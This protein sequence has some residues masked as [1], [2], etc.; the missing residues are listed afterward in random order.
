AWVRFSASVNWQPLTDFQNKELEASEER[1][2]K[3]KQ[4]EMQRKE[5]AR[6]GRSMAPRPPSYPTYTPPSR[7]AVPD[8][9]DSYEAEKKKSFAKYVILRW[10]CSL[11]TVTDG[12]NS[13]PLAVRGKGMQ[14]GKKSKTTDI[15]EKVRGDLGPEEEA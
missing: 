8:T 1:K 15:Y 5:A 11:S 10:F 2:R 14:L 7:P 6:T 12:P 13:R 9:Y 4:L 3:A